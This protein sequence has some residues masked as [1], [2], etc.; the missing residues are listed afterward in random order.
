MAEKGRVLAGKNVLLNPETGAIE[1]L[2]SAKQLAAALT[3]EKL[4]PIVITPPAPR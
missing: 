2:R 3:G 4:E 1:R